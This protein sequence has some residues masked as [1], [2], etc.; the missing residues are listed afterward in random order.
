MRIFLTLLATAAMISSYCQETQKSEVKL[1]ADERITP[2]KPDKNNNFYDNE[3]TYKLPVNDLFI[4]GE[5]ENPGKVD[6]SG[7]PK[8]SV[9]VKEALLKNDTTNQFTGAY[10]YDGY[11]LFDILS[12][13]IISKKNE[14]NF[15]PIIDMDAEIENSKG[16]KV[17]LSWGEIYYPTIL[18]NIII[19]TEVMRIVPSKSKDL[20]PLPSES[21]LVV[22]NDLV[23]ERNISAPSKITV[24]SYARDYVVNRD[25]SPFY[26]GHFEL[27]AGENKLTSFS[28]IPAGFLQETI[29]AIFY[30][31]GRGIHTTQSFSGTPAR[32]FLQGKTTVSKQSLEQGLVI[33]AGIDGYRSV[34]SFSEI[35]N[36]SDQAE[37]LVV[38]SSDN[39]DGGK[40]RIF[41]S[42]DF[43]SDRA[44]KALS[45]IRLEFLPH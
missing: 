35:M 20:W 1:V 9:I 37:I 8:H 3:P 41:P 39:S 28:E 27:I 15:K 2:D 21:K 10:R 31:R 40:F 19:A 4:A 7:L 45:E 44:V 38:P 29:H 14:K 26:A 36:R 18:H 22:G 23:S 11:S 42:C 43:F 30:G 32:M 5:V 24:R 17:V 16:D 6:F 12:E 13:R 25:I 34:F 33:F